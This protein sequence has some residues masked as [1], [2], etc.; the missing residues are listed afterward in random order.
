MVRNSNPGAK[1]CEK[2]SAFFGMAQKGY[3]VRTWRSLLF[4][5]IVSD[6]DHS[7]Y[8]RRDH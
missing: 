4:I 1:T 2:P 6:F 3:G 8:N 7:T 5:Y